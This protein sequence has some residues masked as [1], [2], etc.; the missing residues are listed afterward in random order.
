MKLHT[1]NVKGSNILFFICIDY[2]CGQST[3]SYTVGDEIYSP[4]FKY[5]FC[6][7]PLSNIFP[8]IFPST[9]FSIIFNASIFVFYSC[10]SVDGNAGPTNGFPGNNP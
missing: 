2:Q 6:L 4:S 5:S 8:L 9:F 1:W 7:L 10:M 3:S